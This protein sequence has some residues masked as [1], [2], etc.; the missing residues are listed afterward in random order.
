M[1]WSVLQWTSRVLTATFLL[2]SVLVGPLAPAALDSTLQPSSADLQVLR[3]TPEGTDVSATRQIVVTFDRP[4]APLGDMLLT[5]EKAPAAI[6][7]AVKCH[8]HWLD[9]RSLGCELD[10]A[11]ALLPAT[12]YAITV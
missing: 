6:E 9:P 8:W 11:D 4:M 2:G 12:E 10:G 1:K 5:A 3:V 7:P